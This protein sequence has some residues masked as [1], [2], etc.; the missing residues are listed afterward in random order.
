MATVLHRG[1]I[2]TPA[3]PAVTAMVIDGAT[4]T[5]LGTDDA[6]AV[7][8]GPGD[9]VVDLAG[10]LVTPA[11]VDAHVHATATG[12][13]LTGLDLRGTRSAAQVLDRL[14][15][16]ASGRGGGA[17][18]SDGS[19]VVLGSGWDESGWDDPTPPSAQELSRAAGG[20]PVYLA[21]VDAHSALVSTDL[22][23]SELTGPRSASGYHPSGWFRGDAHDAV[24]TAALARLSPTGRRA[25]QRACLARAAASGIGSVHEMAG[26]TISGADD[27][28]LLLAGA[29]E[30]QTTAGPEVV[31]YWGELDGIETARELGAAGAAGDLFC[32]GAL[33]S[34]TA[35]LSRPYTDRP[36]LRP[37]PRFTVAEVSGHV[38]ACTRVGL[39]AGFHAIGDAAVDTVLAGMDAAA[40]EL[41]PAAVRGAGHRLE[42]AEMV[43]DPRRFAA[44]GLIA[45]VQP[46]FDAAWGGSHGM[47]A[48]RLGE[49]APGLNDFAALS[50]AGVAL[51]FGSDSPVTP[52]DPWGSVRAAAYHRTATSSLSVRAAFTA[53]T[54]GGWRAARRDGDGSGVLA[55]GHPA[56]YAV[57][58]DVDL[59]ID[60]PDERVSRWS[61]DPRAG[62]AGLPDVA[63]DRPLPRCL[64]TVV[65][66]RVVYDAEQTPSRFT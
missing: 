56:T 35:S 27:L 40:A 9:T 11:F 54:R 25:A 60:V 33:G 26:P 5:W 61:T 19:G 15:A 17:G 34:H 49:R 24:R 42:H 52:L 32:D 10:A 55:V 12:L 65:R 22:L 28:A 6:V 50:S 3:G 62:V 30:D 58:D 23:T 21:R 36:D 43:G 48:Q 8:L 31:G 20:R 1:R 66:G 16:F 7:H 41:G 63:P 39:Q 18:G 57:W 13:A 37:N 45:S 46:A 29:S 64:R 47:Y 44:S 51:A 53:H 59:V 4:V 14:A 38:V 2:Y